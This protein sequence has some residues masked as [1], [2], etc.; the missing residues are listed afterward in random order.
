MNS[1][2]IISILLTITLVISFS[3]DK[4]ISLKPN[5]YVWSGSPTN[6]YDTHIV[7]YF[8]NNKN[9]IWAILHW[10]GSGQVAF[11][12]EFILLCLEPHECLP[13]DELKLRKGIIIETSRF[14]K[15][16]CKI[17]RLR[18]LEDNH[19]FAENISPDRILLK[20][21][22]SVHGKSNFDTGEDLTWLR[23]NVKS[24]RNGRKLKNLMMPLM[25][26]LSKEE[27]AQGIISCTKDILI[28]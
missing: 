12:N 13:P 23:F 24:R 6:D 17:V 27:N 4:T 7:S 22:G 18:V 8:I 19:L 25:E 16:S 11:M 1:K 20:Y 10:K 9:H 21:N 5:N 15:E 14:N 26:F 3:C 28:E 2:T